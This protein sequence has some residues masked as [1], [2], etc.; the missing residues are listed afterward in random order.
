MKGAAHNTTSDPGHILEANMQ[1][2]IRTLHAI[3]NAH[4]D[5]VWLWR[6]PEGL[7]TIRAT[8]RSALDRME[9]FPDF[10]FTCSSSAFYALL[11][12]VE[13]DLLDA[14]AAR[15]R[16]GRWELVGGWWVEPDANVPS[17]ES[18]LRQGLYG[19]R[20]LRARFGRQATVGYNP[21]TFGHPATLPQILR[22]VGISRYVFMRPGPHEKELPGPVFIWRSPDGSEVLTAR[23]ARSYATRPEEIA[24]HVRACCDAASPVVSDYIVFYGVGNHGGGPTR[25]NIASLLRQDG[26]EAPFVVKLSRLD[27]FFEAAEADARSGAEVPVVAEELQYH[28]RGCY[29]A[30][31]EIKRNNRRSEH[32]LQSAERVSWLARTLTDRDYP[33]EQLRAAWK[34]LLFT[35]FHDVLAGTSLPEAYQDA[36]DAQGHAAYVASAALYS[37]AQAIASRVDTVGPGHAV[38]LFNPLPWRIRVP[39]EIERG[40]THLSTPSGERMLAQAVQPTTV[41]GQRR[42]CF[43]AE[44]PALGYTTIREVE[45]ASDPAEPVRSLSVKGLEHENDWWRLSVSPETGCISLLYD[46]TLGLSLIRN[47]GMALVCIEDPSDTWSHGV[48]SFRNEAGRFVGTQA[49]VEEDGPVRAAIRTV[50]TWGSGRAVHRIRIY[51]DVPLIEGELTITWNERQRALKLAMPLAMADG[52]ATYEIAYGTASRPADGSE[53]PAQQWADLTGWAVPRSDTDVR[54]GVALL[55][56]SKYGY[57]AMPDELRLT[58]LRSPAYAHHD[59]A[60][61]AEDREYLFTD[62]GVHVIRYRLL[63]HS[64][65]VTGNEIARRALEFN[66]P[67]IWVNE[68]A[69]GGPLPASLEFLAASPGNIVITVCK[70][71]EDTDAMVVRAYE[72]D[73]RPTSAHFRSPWSGLQWTA[74]F[75]PHQIRSWLIRNGKAGAITEINALEDAVAM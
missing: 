6:W 64:G 4:I 13:P 46:K 28:A 62:Q 23:I 52:V 41:A 44:L 1:A 19:Q 68:Y 30:V 11:E 73:G 51:R 60:K 74:E 48:A 8:F 27:R 70:K 12:S 10:V 17:G 38:V 3:G 54:F 35:Q 69:H 65:D 72:A 50:S 63:P 61:L 36:R 55:N 2:T 49:T 21:D 42:S 59:P 16:E 18:L 25:A 14:I 56:D 5:P 66:V 24:D 7:E 32:L 47:P 15:V 37:A 33:D 26:A 9:E 20:Y 29:A 58:L 75:A 22:Q 43:V 45:P 57:D 53:Q 31:S 71:A 34:A 39:V 67:P 40:S